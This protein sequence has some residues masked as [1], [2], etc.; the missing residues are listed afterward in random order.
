MAERKRLLIAALGIL[1]LLS[2]LWLYWEWPMTMAS[3]LPEENWVRAELRWGSVTSSYYVPEFVNPDPDRILSQMGAVKLTRAEE[4][5]H[6]DDRYFQIILYKGE[7]YP[8]MIYVGDTGNVQIARELDFDHWQNYEGG[9]AFY[10]WLEN[11]SE[12]LS[13]VYAPPESE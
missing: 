1:L 3:L 8:A 11:Y 5:D 9:E 4:R 13:A 6:L 12:N 2:G 7:P 10:R